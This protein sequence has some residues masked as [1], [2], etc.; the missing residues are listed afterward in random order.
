MTSEKF[1][2][3]VEDL[4]LVRL[5]VTS[6]KK[7]QKAQVKKA[8]EK[9]AAHRLSTS[10]WK[11]LFESA[12]QHLVDTGEITP[13]PLAATDTGR[14]RAQRF[15]GVERLPDNVTWTTLKKRYLVA[16]ALGIG[17][18]EDDSCKGLD[19]ADNLR[20]AVL[21]KEYDL[22]THECPTI[23]QAAEA[24]AWQQLNVRTDQ[25]FSKKAVIAFL[26][27]RALGEENPPVDQGRDD[28]DRHVRNQ[29]VLKSIGAKVASGSQL[30]D[31]TLRHWIER[32]QQESQH[33]AREEVVEPD[34][35]KTRDLA[36]AASR[37][38]D[39]ARRCEQGRFGDNKVFISHVWKQLSADGES[40]IRDFRDFQQLLVDAHRQGMLQLSQA[41]LVEAMNPRDVA[42]SRTPYMNMAFHFIRI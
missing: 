2:N 14:R 36:D 31:A 17:R 18:P 15:L 21:R 27:R 24:L 9:L 23:N 5:L 34:E 35:P 16:K 7:T 26:I 8:V 1:R 42:E 30:H 11:E 29:A 6:E 4:I 10:E 33:S 37:I 41:D 39:A 13:R 20:G 12:F 38:L 32:A 28:P 19:K 3:L 40:V 22:A 25:P